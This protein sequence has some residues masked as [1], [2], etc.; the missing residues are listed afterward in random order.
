MSHAILKGSL[1]ALI[2]FGL[3]VPA[4]RACADPALLGLVMPDAKMLFGI[5]AGQTQASPIG[6][7]LLSQIQLD[8]NASKVMAAAGFDPRRDLRE[9]LAASGD[10]AGGLLLGRGS[11]QPGK[12]AKAAEAAGAASSTYRGVTLVTFEGSGKNKP[13]G[14]IALLDASTVA[15]G[16]NATVKAAIDRRAAGAVFSGQLADKAR[17]ISFANDAWIATLTPPAALLNAAQSAQLGPLQNVLQSALQ[18]SAGV[19]FAAT[20]VTLSAEVVA[21][22]PQDAQAMADVL[23][24]GLSLLQQAN[25]P[26]PSASPNASKPPSLADAAQ[27]SSSGSAMHLVISVPEQQLE[28]LLFPAAPGPPKKVAAR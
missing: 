8:R 7:Y 21:R 24:F 26:D 10:G 12:I 28:Q 2:A 11:F 4:A 16:D 15:A 9:I 5:E 1:A 22:S 18:L 6:Q 25:R 14:S 19:K 13:S 27:I 23:R 17:Q 20:Q 3:F